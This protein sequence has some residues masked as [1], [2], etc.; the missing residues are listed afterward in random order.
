MKIENIGQKGLR[1]FRYVIS[2]IFTGK[3][4]FPITLKLI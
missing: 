1:Y 4:Y 3:G 2:F